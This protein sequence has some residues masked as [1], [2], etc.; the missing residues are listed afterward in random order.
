MKQ[1]LFT[2]LFA[3]AVSMGTM[4]AEKVQIGN[5]YYNLN[6]TNRTAEVIQRIGYE[7][8]QLVIY[9]GLTTANIP[10]SVSYTAVTYNV[11][12]IGDYA[13]AGCTSLTSVTIPNSAQ[14]L[15]IMHSKI[16]AV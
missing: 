7:G 12:S 3:V 10:S 16:A 2:L 15:E 5:L 9:S 6:A 1:K 14:A 13:F 8:H 11:T 4:Y